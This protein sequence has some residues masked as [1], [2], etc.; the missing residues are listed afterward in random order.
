VFV[1]DGMNAVEAGYYYAGVVGISPRGL[2]LQQLW[3]MAEVVVM[4]GR[5]KT[6]EL[7]TLVWS[8]GSIDVDDYLHYGVLSET[9]NGGPVQLTPEMQARVE[10]AAEKIRRENPGLPTVRGLTHV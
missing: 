3:K 10:E 6:L 1:I 5:R 4:A 2:T 9:G 8:M 7:A